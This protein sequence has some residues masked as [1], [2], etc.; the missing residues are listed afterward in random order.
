MRKGDII[1][2]FFSSVGKPKD[3]YK[4]T[5]DKLPLGVKQGYIKKSFVFIKIAYRV[6]VRLFV[7]KMDRMLLHA[8]K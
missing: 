6:A 7:E 2:K 5:E 8:P 4:T 1:N 3:Q